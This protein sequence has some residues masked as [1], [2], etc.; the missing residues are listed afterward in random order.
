LS[1][2]ALCE[3]GSFSEV[4]PLTIHPGIKNNLVF[5]RRRIKAKEKLDSTS[6]NVGTS[7]S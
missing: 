1:S 4:G 5:W 2:E 3:R 7:E 6:P